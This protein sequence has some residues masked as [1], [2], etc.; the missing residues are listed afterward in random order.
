MTILITLVSSGKGTW[1]QVG[2]LIN[3]HNWDQVYLVCS[4]FA[5]ENFKIDQNKA[6]KL[7]FDEDNLN[8]GFEKLSLFFKNSINE[9]EVAINLYSGNGMEHMALVSSILKAGLGIRFV[10]NNQGKIE[11]FKLLNE[12]YSIIKEDMNNLM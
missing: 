9:F 10:Y 8:E 5:Y 4:N 11:E 3:T 2:D 6:L 12:D 1:K 7:K